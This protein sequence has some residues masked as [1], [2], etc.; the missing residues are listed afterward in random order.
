MVLG[1]LLAAPA[2]AVYRSIDQNRSLTAAVDV[3]FG[4]GCVGNGLARLASVVCTEPT[5]R[6][7]DRTCQR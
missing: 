4:A 2:A 6:P 3:A 7:T 1:F 5:D